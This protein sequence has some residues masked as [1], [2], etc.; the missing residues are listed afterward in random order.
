MGVGMSEPLID[1]QGFPRGD[2]DVHLVTILRH[3]VICLQNDH[4]AHMHAIEKG[5]IEF[6]AKVREQRAEQPSAQS[7]SEVDDCMCFDFFL[8]T[9]C[10]SMFG[11]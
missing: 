2:V 8:T 7:H 4:K 3:D 11:K 1:N 10:L 9:S 5:L 6:H